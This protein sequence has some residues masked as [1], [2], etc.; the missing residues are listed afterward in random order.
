MN[1]SELEKTISNKLAMIDI[2]NK[3]TNGAHTSRKHLDEL[4]GIKQA[5]RAMGIKVTYSV[6]P[7]F[8]EDKEP[9]TF[10]L[11][12]LEKVATQQ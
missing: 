9:S 8:Y 11:E 10:T 2:F 5:C 12:K 7:Y 1:T 6:N 4:T 3:N